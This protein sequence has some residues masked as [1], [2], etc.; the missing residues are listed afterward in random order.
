MFFAK[1][2]YKQWVIHQ[3]DVDTAYLNATLDPFVVHMKP[4]QGFR[5]GDETFCDDSYICKQ[6]EVLKLKKALYGL[7]QSGKQW[8]EDLTRFI[9]SLGYKRARCDHCLFT[10]DDENGHNEILIYVDDI[11]IA[12]D[13]I[14]ETLWVKAEFSSKYEMKDLGICRAFLG[15]EVHQDFEEATV[16]LTLKQTISKLIKK[17][18][19]GSDEIYPPHKYPADPNIKLSEWMCPTSEKEKSEMEKLP[20]RS[21]LGMLQYIGDKCRHDILPAINNV[22]S[23]ACNPGFE[24]WMALVLIVRYLKHTIDIGL[25][26]GLKCNHN[27]LTAY[28]DANFADGFTTTRSRSGGVIMLGNSLVRA[29]SHKQKTSATF[30][31][32]AE[33]MALE[34]MAREALFFRDLAIEMAIYPYHKHSTHLDK[35]ITIY[36]DNTA[37]VS[38]TDHPGSNSTKFLEN[39]IGFIRDEVEN[40]N[41]KVVYINTDDNLAD[42]FTKPLVGKRFYD[43]RYRLGFR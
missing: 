11:L 8:Y 30:T 16:K 6:G 38:L 33:I 3:M 4:P 18:N 43:L 35:S 15:M 9:R 12:G 17:F 40:G 26:L 21:L 19:F 27:R 20:F 22:N 31:A 7:K 24:H 32:H 37:A 42:F 25:T 10:K 36:E 14:E 23:F 29:Y 28:A 34:E 1:S 13:S 5:E 2:A 41:L 39:R